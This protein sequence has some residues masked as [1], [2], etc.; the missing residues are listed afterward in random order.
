VDSYSEQL[1]FHADCLSKMKLDGS[2]LAQSIGICESNLSMHSSEYVISRP[3]LH[4]SSPGSSDSSLLS[5]STPRTTEGSFCPTFDTFE[6]SS[7]DQREP[8]F[9]TETLFSLENDEAYESQSIAP[10]LL[11][12]NSINRYQDH[13]HSPRN[14][15]ISPSPPQPQARLNSNYGELHSYQNQQT[16]GLFSLRRINSIEL[17]SSKFS[18]ASLETR[19]FQTVTQFSISETDPSMLCVSPTPVA[20]GNSH[21]LQFRDCNITTSPVSLPPSPIVDNAYLHEKQHQQQQYSFPMTPQPSNISK[22]Q[23]SNLYGHSYILSTQIASPSDAAL[24]ALRLA[25]P[26]CHSQLYYASSASDSDADEL[27]S[28][29]ERVRRSSPLP[30]SPILRHIRRCHVSKP[31]KGDFPLI[32]SSDDKPHE[33]LIS[34]CRKRFKRQEHLRRHERTHTQE[35]PFRCEVCAKMF[36]RTDNLK[37]H[38]RTHT[39]RKGGRNLFVPGLEVI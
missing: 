39:K 22:P 17:P 7:H 16:P 34:T 10:K 23:H 26:T 32:V 5:L 14:I 38:L 6:H 8:R 19:R 37:A 4:R 31:A 25:M 11:S 24:T 1:N 15:V 12:L 13:E 33:C 28:E 3:G 2:S 20:S 29:G 35:R 30:S 9:F 27:M 21:S 18:L 36:G